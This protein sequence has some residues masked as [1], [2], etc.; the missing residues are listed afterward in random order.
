MQEMYCQSC[1]MPL[2]S[3]LLG[4]E[5]D[6]QKSAEYCLYCYENG[7]YKESGITMEQMIEM[8]VPHMKAH[9]MPEEEARKLMNSAL[10]QLKRWQK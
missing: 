6:G 3:Q 7:A 5:K 2:T 1:G 9:G 10:P 4:T 8:C